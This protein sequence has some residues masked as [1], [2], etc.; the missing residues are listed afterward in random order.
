MPAQAKPNY[1]A[2]KD[3]CCRTIQLQADIEAGYAV[4]YDGN[5]P[6]AGSSIRGVLKTSG[7]AGDYVTVT[8]GG[9]PSA[10]VGAAVSY[11]QDLATDATGKLVPA[12]S[13]DQ[14]VARAL[15]VS[16][17]ADLFITVEL[18]KETIKP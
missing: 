5:L 17:A 10:I 3:E 18:C 2:N 11:G 13:G 6:T 8:T 12:V 1:L 14:I 9:E 7:V 16:A 4:G 15:D